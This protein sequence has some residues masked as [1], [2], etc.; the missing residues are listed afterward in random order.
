MS[1]VALPAPVQAIVDAIN[2][3]DTDAFVNGFTSDGQVDDWGRVLLGPTGVRSWADTDAI[4]M[5]ASMDVT[6]A[7]TTDSVTHLV[8]NWSSNRFNGTSE[9]YVTVSE[10]KVSSFRIP[11]H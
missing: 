2:N 10:G 7:T 4:G 9:A 8:F 3:G 1:T 11:A 6:S 5:N